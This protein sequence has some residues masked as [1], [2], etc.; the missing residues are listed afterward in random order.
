ME[1]SLQIWIAYRSMHMVSLI[2]IENVKLRCSIVTLYHEFP[3]NYH[4]K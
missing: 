4:R 3:I 2:E 1:Y